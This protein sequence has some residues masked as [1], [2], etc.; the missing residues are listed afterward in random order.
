[1]NV[2]Y[3]Y[4]TKIIGNPYMKRYADKLWWCLQVEYDCYGHKGNKELIFNTEEEAKQVKGWI[5]I[6]SVNYE[7]SKIT[8]F[9]EI[10]HGKDRPYIF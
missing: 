9:L 10:H 2:L 4:V 6:S 1:M 5:C 3:H 8:V 7:N